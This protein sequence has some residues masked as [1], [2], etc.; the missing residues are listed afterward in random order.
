MSTSLFH[1]RPALV[2]LVMCQSPE[3]RSSQCHDAPSEHK[4]LQ[5]DC[6]TALGRQR[7]PTT[8]GIERL[9]RAAGLTAYPAAAI[10][11]TLP[12]QNPSSRRRLSQAAQ[13]NHIHSKAI[14]SPS[15][16]CPLLHR[17]HA[18]VRQLEP[19][20]SRA[21]A[22]DMPSS[23]VLPPSAGSP[24]RFW[25]SRMSLERRFGLVRGIGETEP[26]MTLTL[27]ASEI[28]SMPVQYAPSAPAAPRHSRPPTARPC[29]SSGR[30]ADDFA[31]LPP[32]PASSGGGL[33]RAMSGRYGFG[34]TAPEQD[35]QQCVNGDRRPQ[36]DTG[37]AAP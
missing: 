27:P 18:M 8:P 36:Q 28:P 23:R 15:P 4:Q 32:C 3:G 2:F 24:R 26:T 21:P 9:P 35:R 34:M 37:E 20:H 16:E 5:V 19:P 10:A 30:A 17:E 6:L 12:A 29:S 25:C 31:L 11:V 7:R 22:G 13:T 1:G 14:S 33:E